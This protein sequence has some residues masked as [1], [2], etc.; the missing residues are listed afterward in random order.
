MG[1]P[2]WGATIAAFVA[3]LALD[4]VVFHRRDAGP[5]RL[6]EAVIWSASYIAIALLFGL[7]LGSLS[8]WQIGT[9][10]YAAYLLEK[11]MSVDNLFVFVV[12][13]SA[14]A[15]PPELR[16]RALSIGIA[17]ALILRVALIALGAALIDAFS[18]TFLIFGAVLLLTAVQLMRN[19]D[20]DPSIEDNPLIALARRRLPLSERY[21]AG[22]LTTRANG[23]LLFTPMFLVVLG[24]GTADLIFA[25]DS[26]PAAF[27]VTQR[28][29]VVF[30]ANAF[31]LLGLRPLFFLV[32]GLLDR[33]VYLSAGLAVIL[34]LIGV[35]LVLH[36]AHAQSSSIP[37]ISTPLSLIAI[38]VILAITV[39]ASVI[40]ARR[41]RDARAHAGSLLGH[42][43]PVEAEPATVSDTTSRR[44]R[45]PEMDR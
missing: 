42:E 19:R 37:E 29:Y 34:G 12:I 13:V 2:V 5:V 27:G 26:I 3:L 40:Y 36:F 35:K 17:I 28:A 30:A 16:P 4:M 22:S 23:R 9:Q 33:L 7:L 18:F 44:E 10:Y 41:H 38:A 31:A 25:L 14:F 24:V 32:A 43:T 39:I 11:S 45:G 21:Q 15:V 20:M 8:G 1:A 6:R